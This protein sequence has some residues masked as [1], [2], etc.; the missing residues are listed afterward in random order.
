MIL[1]IDWTY[2]TE[3]SP[4]GYCC[5]VR[6]KP[7]EEGGY[8]AYVPALRGA[9]SEGGD[10]PSALRNISEALTGCLSTYLEEKMPIPWSEPQS[11]QPGELSFRMAVNL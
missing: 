9:I 1:K 2:S 5:D 11:P 10:I 7:D 6:L 4:L 3:D 8:V